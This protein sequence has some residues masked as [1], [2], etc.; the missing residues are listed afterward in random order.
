MSAPAISEFVNI[1]ISVQDAVSDRVNFGVLMGVFAHTV[2]ANRV[3]GPYSDINA[4]TSAG[5]TAA[6][7]PEVFGWASSVF[8]QQQG[9][10]EIKI[11]L[12]TVG[13]AGD[14]TVTM[15]AV[16]ADDDDYYGLNVETRAE[17]DILNVAAHVEPSGSTEKPKIYIAQSSDAALLAGTAGNIG[18]D[19]RTQTYHRTALIHHAIDD[20]AGGSDESDGY[21]DGAWSSRCLGFDLD[22]PNGRG[23]WIFKQLVGVPY[24]DLTSAQVANVY[25]EN[26]NVYGIT[27][28]LSFPSKGTMASGRFIDI[29]TSVDWLKARLEESIIETLVNDPVGLDMTSV[30]LGKLTRA[31]NTVLGNGV[32]Y[33]HLTPDQDQIFRWPTPNQISQADRTARTLTGTGTLYLAGGIVQVNLNITVVP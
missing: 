21:L 1:T 32:L 12:Q 4:V 7:E 15:P 11:G 29:T 20:S 17:A 19:L 14:W 2:N 28:G 31:T 16:D 33:G 24:N 25:A 9:V 22:A 13:D 18:E 26:A 3:N 10:D 23:Q 5:F 27:K 8:N 6:A 30:G